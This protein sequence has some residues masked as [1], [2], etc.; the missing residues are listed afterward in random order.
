MIDRLVIFGA[1]GDLTAR[2]LLPGLAALRAAGLHSERFAMTGSGSE[3]WD[4]EHFRSWSAEQ[5]D[6][7]AAH[8][9]RRTGRRWCRRRRTARLTCAT[10]RVSRASL[11]ATDR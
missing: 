4:S 10:R 9:P 8:L 7:H 6:R 3:D 11:R 1:T 2:Y 5:L